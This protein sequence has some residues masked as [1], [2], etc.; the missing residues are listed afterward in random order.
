[1][2]GDSG[3]SNSETLV[4]GL[5]MKWIIYA[6]ILAIFVS[7]ALVPAFAKGIDVPGDSNGDKVVSA[8]ELKTA[9]KLSQ[10]GKITK[11]QLDEIR[12]IHENYPKTI[13]DSANNT[14]KVY[15]PIK[16]VV[17]AYWI[18]GAITLQALK[19]EDS[20]V[21]V[22]DS[23]KNEPTLFP[24]LSN[25][26]SVGKMP[27]SLDFE[28][29]LELKPDT[30]IT[31]GN[32]S[33]YDEIQ[34]K[35]QSLDPNIVVLRFDYCR[36]AS[37]PDEVN[38]TGYILN[39]KQEAKELIDF[40]DDRLSQIKEKVSNIPRDKRIKVYSEVFRD[41]ATGGTG[42]YYPNDYIEMAGGINIF[43]DTSQGLFMADPEE[44]IKRNP[45]IILYHAGSDFYGKKGWVTDNVTALR[46][47]RDTILNRTGFD[48]VAA[49]KNG[50]AYTLD[51]NLV[52]EAFYPVGLS[53]YAKWFYPELFNDLDP[54]A[55]HKE[56]LNKILHI[57]YDPS[58]HGAFVYHPQE[59]PD[60][61]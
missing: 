47:K 23:I 12:D 50:K 20:V 2:S 43:G 35:S 58:K 52:I 36:P 48:N 54:I 42:N 34:K 60:G 37:Y 39:R 18:G 27:Q 5:V 31:G 57:D 4:G 61:R 24:K 29:I 53:Y 6:L 45:E 19:A 59:D 15:T 46:E 33:S 30:I 44:I 14:V 22:T 1:M 16:R 7:N 38:K 25:L 40:I 41:Y 55:I 9:E 10:D 56:Y 26:P 8:E 32:G 51:A 13:T 21:G 49:V 3:H 11:E 28:K 17:I